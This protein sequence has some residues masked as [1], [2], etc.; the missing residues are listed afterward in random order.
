MPGTERR[1]GFDPTLPGDRAVRAGSWGRGGNAGTSEIVRF[2]RCTGKLNA[3][4]PGVLAISIPYI[5]GLGAPCKGS[6]AGAQH[7]SLFTGSS[8]KE[9]LTLRFYCGKR[10]ARRHGF[11]GEPRNS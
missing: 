9:P 3:T 11:G 4:Q 6:V 7:S 5:R 2:H 10:A 1:S 8:L